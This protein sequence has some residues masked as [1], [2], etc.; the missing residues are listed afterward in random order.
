MDEQRVADYFVVAGLGE[1]ALPLEE[2]SNE[3]AI[4]PSYHQDPIIDIAVINRSAGEKVP[5]NYNCLELTP[6]GFPANLN[7]GAIR[8]PDLFICYRRGRDKPPLKDIGILYEG[9]ERVMEGCEV[10]HTTPFGRP[11]NVNNSNSSRI[12]ITYRRASDTAASDTLVVVDLCIILGNKGEEPPLTYNQ[13]HK[14]LNKGMVGSDVFLCYKKAMVKTDVLAYKPTI[15]GRYPEEDYENFPLPES[16]PM[17]CLPMGATVE[18]WSAKAKHPLPT[19]STFILTLAG[20]EKVYGAAVSF[21]EEFPESQL[22]DMQMRALGL[23]NRSIREQYNI[24]RTVHVRKAICLLSHWPFFDAFKK[25]LSQ[26]YKMS[27][28]GPHTV[29]IERHISHFMYDVPYPSPQRPRILVQLAHGS[30]SLCMPEDSPLPQSGASFI[31]LLRNLGPE[32]CINLLLYTL[33]ENKILLHSLR[34]TVLTEVAEAVTS[35]IFPF[36]WQC[37]YIPLCP[38]GLSDVLNAPCPFIVGIDSRYFD[39]YDPPPDIICVDLDTS[40]I[41]LPEDKKQLIFKIMPKKAVRLLQDSLYRLFEMAAPDTPQGNEDL[42]VEMANVDFDF[43]RKK[44]QMQMELLIQEAFLR[45]MAILLRDYKQYLNPITKQPNSR[46]TDASSLFDMQGFL[47]SRDK[48]NIKF[49]TQMMKT[50]M[51]FRFIEERSFVS[52]KD[53]SLAFFDECTE[54]ISMNDETREDIRLIEIDNSKTS[55]RTVFITPPEPVGLPEGVTYS[56]D[57]FP[58]LKPEL[59]LKKKLSTLS[60]PGKQ[61]VCPNSP[62]ARRSKQEIKS[63]QKLALQHLGKPNSWARC[64]LAQC[65]SLWFISFPAFIHCH[66]KKLEALKVG[67]AVLQKM[68]AARPPFVDQVCYRVLMQL[69]GQYNK[70]GLA[71]QVLSLMK[72]NGVQPNAITYGYYNRVML[73]AK[74]P[75]PMSKGKLRWT[76]IRN[77]IIGVAQFRKAIRRRSLSLY[78]NSGS[79]YDQISHA[80]VDSYLDD[81]GDKPATETS[82]KPV[83]TPDIQDTN[84]GVA[85]LGDTGSGSMT[86]GGGMTTVPANMEDRIRG[87]SDMGYNSMTQEDVHHLSKLMSVEGESLPSSTS[88]P[89]TSESDPSNTRPK[90]KSDSWNPLRLSFRQ[91]KPR[92][93]VEKHKTAESNDHQ[94]LHLCRNHTGSIVRKSISSF[95]EQDNIE[96]MKGILFGSSAGLLM[97][98]QVFLEHGSYLASGDLRQEMEEASRRRHK[99]EGAG[100]PKPAR[101]MS[102]F[103]SWRPKSS[104]NGDSSKVTPVRFSELVRSEEDDV[105]FSSV[106]ST[107]NVHQK[108]DVTTVLISDFPSEEKSEIKD[109]GVELDENQPLGGE[110]ETGVAEGGCGEGTSLIELA[111]EEKYSIVSTKTDMEQLVDMEERNGCE[112]GGKGDGNRNGVDLTQVVFVGDLGSRLGCVLPVTLE[113]Q[114]DSPD[115]MCNSRTE[116]NA[117]LRGVDRFVSTSDSSKSPS[118]LE[119]VVRRASDTMASFKTPASLAALGRTMSTGAQ[120]GTAPSTPSKKQNSSQD[121]VN[122]VSEPQKST[123]STSEYTFRRSHSLRLTNDMMQKTNEAISGFLRFASKAAY[124]KLNELKQSITTPI[125]NATSQSSLARS[126]EELDGAGSDRGSAVGC[127]DGNSST[128]GTVKER[129]RMGGSQDMLS[130][131]ESSFTES[132]GQRHSQTSFGSVP[133]P[134]YLDNFCPLREIRSNSIGANINDNS[135]MT[136]A[137]EVEMSSCSRC[138]RCH[139]LVYDEE[140]MAGWSADDSNLNTSCPFCPAK[141]VPNLQVYVKDWRGQRKSMMLSTESSPEGLCPSADPA[142]SPT[143]PTHISLTPTLKE[144]TALNENEVGSD[145]D[146]ADIP[147]TMVSSMHLDEFPLSLEEAAVAVRRRCTSECLS[148]ISETFGSGDGGAG[149]GYYNVYPGGTGPSKSPL[150]LSGDDE[151]DLPTHPSPVPEMK[152]D[153]MTR[154]TCTAEP[155]VFPYLSPL[156][157]RKELEYVIDHEGD[158]CLASQSFLEQHPILFWNL[159]W[160]W[161][162]LEVPTHLSNFLLST[163]SICSPETLTKQQDMYDS[164]NVLVRT[165]WDNVRIHDEVGLPMYMAWNAGHRSTVVDALVTEAES[166]SRPLM[167]QIISSI[168]RSD[169]LNAIKQVMGGRRRLGQKRRFRSMYREI[170][171]LS[172][173]ACGRE[174]IDHDA[175]DREYALAFEK[176]VPRRDP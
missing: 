24:Q 68:Q 100:G 95:S 176:T 11:A 84:A 97:V 67:L 171:F 8:C 174:N 22:T 4:K 93:H 153:F 52:D 85:S 45:F 29:P 57:S 18:S 139:R 20:G 59:F 16:V 128:S 137:M 88:S 101:S 121:S 133:S 46:A 7:H 65:Y 17:F 107:D 130:T 44:K 70:P 119:S 165:L 25:F 110:N 72:K 122:S 33:L 61:A 19:F 80:S 132:V 123:E 64:L 158:L 145:K 148:S 106:H 40:R 47:K 87:V 150:N 115:N 175:F 134:S 13:I 48:A 82:I 32:L 5:N 15:L 3:A 26:L 146:D 118:T 34:P 170:L 56:Y 2:I 168:Q 9:K 126:S 167:Y 63:S 77:V 73:E 6:T 147:E 76:K 12:Y 36:H 42:N 91:R 96:N 142:L 164:Q 116:E 28:T 41:W 127:D 131:S 69:A 75:S 78:S 160:Y 79:E 94:N 159:I 54:T 113:E 55:D 27:V 129:Q 136:I 60:L 37:P 172:F 102:L 30:L 66:P 90:S 162:R 31:T 163:G 38:L 143:S 81:H 141:F 103:A 62:L 135:L 157:L 117:V 161:R 43:K 14:N 109:S 125:R 151:V 58:Q 39:L 155:Q 152:K 149:N 166:F 83:F 98:S 105:S 21:Y 104:T 51:F 120:P 89:T 111:M 140:I 49:Y 173:V 1:G 86:E 92:H 23:K 99:S 154:S 71:V 10:V 169:M 112:A 124:S 114:P 35:M 156:V 144:S 108:A 50:Q 53:A 138:G 74:W